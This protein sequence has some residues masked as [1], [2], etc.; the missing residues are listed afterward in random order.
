[1]QMRHPYAHFQAFSRLL[2]LGPPF[3][4]LNTTW[5]V[6]PIVMLISPK[7]LAITCFLNGTNNAFIR[8]VSGSKIPTWRENVAHRI[9]ITDFLSKLYTMGYESSEGSG[10]RLYLQDGLAS[11]DLKYVK[12][13]MSGSVS[14]ELHGDHTCYTFRSVV[15]SLCLM[16]LLLFA[17]ETLDISI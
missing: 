16:V 8:P 1:M 6:D 14:E 17:I 10:Y 2:P 15:P 12:S 4:L 5:L 11:R 13:L 7:H 9:E 3:N